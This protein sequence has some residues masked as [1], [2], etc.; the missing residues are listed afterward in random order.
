MALFLEIERKNDNKNMEE[1]ESLKI[2]EQRKKTEREL[3][4]KIEEEVWKEHF[5]GLLEGIE[6]EKEQKRKRRLRR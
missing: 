6:E 1:A 3:G 2:Y 4:S 5:K